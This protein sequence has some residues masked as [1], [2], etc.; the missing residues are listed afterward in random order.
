MLINF[1]D[2]EVKIYLF[3]MKTKNIVERYIEKHALF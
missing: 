1:M 2:I 3:I